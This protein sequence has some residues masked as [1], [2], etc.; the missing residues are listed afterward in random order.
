MLR[1]M[2]EKLTPQ[3]RSRYEKI[4]A[5]ISE[6]QS[7]VRRHQTERRKLLAKARMRALRESN[8]EIQDAM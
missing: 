3:E 4:L 1:T 7:E 6:G 5:W 8:K 2:I